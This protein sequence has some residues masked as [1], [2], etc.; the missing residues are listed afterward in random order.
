MNLLSRMHYVCFLAICLA[1]CVSSRAHAA[2]ECLNAV[3]ESRA[4]TSA[5]AAPR[6]ASALSRRGSAITR[7]D[8]SACEAGDSATSKTKW[9]RRRAPVEER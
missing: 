3:K 1:V 8:G 2:A 4:A 9:M 5:A 6:Q 7:I